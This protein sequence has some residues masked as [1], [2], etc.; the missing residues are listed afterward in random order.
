MAN[1]D[2]NELAEQLLERSKAHSVDWED[3]RAGQEY[4]VFFPDL[5]LRI[6]RVEALFEDDS[7]EYRLELTSNTGRLIESLVPAPGDH[8]YHVLSDIFGFAEQYIHD[9]SINKALDYLKSS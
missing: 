2:I 5:A 7:T 6:S 1:P 8:L 9:N 3:T 4:R